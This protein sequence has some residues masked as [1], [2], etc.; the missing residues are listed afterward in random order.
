MQHRSTP[1][2]GEAMES[3][4]SMRDPERLVL[5][6]A[7]AATSVGLVCVA[8]RDAPAIRYLHSIGVS[9]GALLSAIAIACLAGLALSCALFA[10][11][12]HAALIAAVVTYPVTIF[13]AWAL[14]WCLVA[15]SGSP[16]QATIGAALVPALALV[17]AHRT[18]RMARRFHAG[19]GPEPEASQP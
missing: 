16:G 10:R 12:R 3:R 18:R 4:D 19:Q 13:S 5:A 7:W 15:L 17:V 6:L 9:A 11:W 8:V 14:A 2:P 1:E